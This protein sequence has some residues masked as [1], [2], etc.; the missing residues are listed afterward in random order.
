MQTKFGVFRSLFSQKFDE[1]S[2]RIFVEALANYVESNEISLL[3]WQNFASTEAKF[4]LAEIS[5]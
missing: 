4:R 5:P 3:S 1:I 2:P